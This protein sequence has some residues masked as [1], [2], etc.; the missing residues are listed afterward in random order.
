MHSIWT[1]KTAYASSTKSHLSSYKML[2]GP[3]LIEI[4]ISLSEL[5]GVSRGKRA[6]RMR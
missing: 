1:V 5:E 2:S 6:K 4:L 3:V